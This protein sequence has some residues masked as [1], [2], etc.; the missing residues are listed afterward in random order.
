MDQQRN[1]PLE[2]TYTIWGIV[3]I[4]WSLY[5]VYIHMPEWFDELVAKP[6]VFL[7]PMLFYV[8]FQEQ[9]SFA[10]IGLV[11]GRFL[12]D[13]YLGLGFGLLFAVEGIAANSIKYGRLALSPSIPVGGGALLLAVILSIATAFS[14]ELLVRGFLFTRL[15]EAYKSELKALFV[16]TVMYFM[17]LVPIIFTV[18]KLN[19]VPLL[20]FVVTNLV[21][22]LTNTMIFNE[23]RTLTVPILIHAFW[24]MAVVL[25]L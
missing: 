24:N 25:Y 14:E 9:R 4:L 18:L 2:R 5:R 6:F 15:K 23:T 3:L 22:S 11:A 21:I 12:R 19:G 20:L 7:G 17:L 8:V 13:V 10:S 1:I 16:T